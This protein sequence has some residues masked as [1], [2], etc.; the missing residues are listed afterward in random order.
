MLNISNIIIYDKG[1]GMRHAEAFTIMDCGE[2]FNLN[3]VRT[4]EIQQVEEREKTHTNTSSARCMEHVLVR[5]H[6]LRYSE[7][8]HHPNDYTLLLQR[9]WNLES[10]FAW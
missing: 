2:L 1:G 9:P 5:N 6:P 4:M 10:S 8:R 7:M 3:G